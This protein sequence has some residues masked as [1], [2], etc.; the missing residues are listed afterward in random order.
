[1]EPPQPGDG[2]GGLWSW[3]ARPPV[4]EASFWASLCASDCF[5]VKWANTASVSQWLSG[6]S[7]LTCVRHSIR[8]Y[9]SWKCSSISVCVLLFELH[10]LCPTVPHVSV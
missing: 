4:P 9:L 6:R 5:S 10:L 1:M 8:Q 3:P 7:E 2:E